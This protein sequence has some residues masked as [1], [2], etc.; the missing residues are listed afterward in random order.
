MPRLDIDRFHV[1]PRKIRDYLLAP[2]HPA[3]GSKAAFFLSLGFKRDRPW[4]LA[5]ELRS[6][7]AANDATGPVETHYGSKYTV[8]GVLRGALVRTVWIV[9]SPG[10]AVRF[11]T[12]YP[13]RSPT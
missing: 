1:D 5:A 7:G 6:L 4:E 11:V 10:G 13:R 9:D 3:G 12:A 2:D 8:D